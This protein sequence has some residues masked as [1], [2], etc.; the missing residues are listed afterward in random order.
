MYAIQ[1]T[2]ARLDVEQENERQSTLVN[3]MRS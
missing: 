1:F 2:L 3:K